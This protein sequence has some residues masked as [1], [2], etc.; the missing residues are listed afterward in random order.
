MVH[1]RQKRE[2][3]HCEC[4]VDGSSFLMNPFD[5]LDKKPPSGVILFLV[6]KKRIILQCEI[7]HSSSR[8]G[9]AATP[10]ALQRLKVSEVSRLR[11]RRRRRRRARTNP[12]LPPAPAS[13]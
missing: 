4:V 9:A 7:V 6:E 12:A 3:L 10:A 11:L 1:K 5:I 2:K 8:K 13:R